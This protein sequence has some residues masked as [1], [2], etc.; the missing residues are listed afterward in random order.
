MPITESNSS[1]AAKAPIRC[2]R[3]DNFNRILRFW[4]DIAKTI[5]QDI[6]GNTY[7]ADVRKSE[8]ADPILVFNMT[9]GFV[10][11]GVQDLL[12]SKTPL[13]MSAPL[14]GS[15]F[16]DVEETL[17]DGTVRTIAKDVFIIDNDVTP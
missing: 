16:Y 9:D 8:F 15:Y 5:P 14:P 12:M 10:I 3:G 17:P 1:V 4:T 6:T 11:S 7:K 2:M 13:Q